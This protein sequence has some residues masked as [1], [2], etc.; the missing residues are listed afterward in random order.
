M[1]QCVSAPNAVPAVTCRVSTAI[2]ETA[3]ALWRSGVGHD[4]ACYPLPGLHLSCHYHCSITCWQGPMRCH[5]EMC[6][7]TMASPGER[8]WRP[9]PRVSRRRRR[10]RA[11]PPALTLRARRRASGGAAPQLATLTLPYPGLPL[12][13]IQA[14]VAMRAWL[15]TK[16]CILRFVLESAASQSQCPREAAVHSHR[17]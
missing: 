15:T 16:T 8:C 10:A 9:W 14:S 2:G 4:L 13:F 3:G 12:L 5:Q 7:P 17:R 11:S 6:R 1:L